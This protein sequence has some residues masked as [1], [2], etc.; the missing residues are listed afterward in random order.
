MEQLAAQRS[1]ELNIIRFKVQTQNNYSRERVIFLVKWRAHICFYAE[2]TVSLSKWPTQF[3]SPH[4][5]DHFFS[6]TVNPV[7]SAAPTRPFFR[8]NGQLKHSSNAQTTVSSPKWSTH[9]IP[10]HRLDH[11]QRKMVNW[12]QT[13]SASRPFPYQNGQLTDRDN[14]ETAISLS[15]W[16]TRF[17]SLPR[18]D[19]F[20]F[21]A[22]E[23]RPVPSFSSSPVHQKKRRDAS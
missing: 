15:K 18:V 3:Y 13:K 5:L 20:Y 14:L 17:Y 8:Q 9:F 19:R 10:P 23:T 12:L 6:K 22:V 2:S 21:N 7:L 11:F 1:S 4:R 16:S